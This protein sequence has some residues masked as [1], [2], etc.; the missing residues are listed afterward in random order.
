[1]AQGD[2]NVRVER[3]LK[4]THPHWE[5]PGDIPF[6]LT[7]RNEL[8]REPPS[9][10]SSVVALLCR[11]EMTVKVLACHQTLIPKCKVGNWIPGRQGPS[12]TT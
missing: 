9:L 3:H 5:G 1:M 12:G 10:K 2:R 4:P 11:S 8:V 7:V 6:T